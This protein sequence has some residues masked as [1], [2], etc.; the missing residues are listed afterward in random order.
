AQLEKLMENMRAEVGAHPPV[1]GSYSPRRGDFCI[2][3]FVDGEWYRARVEKVESG[4]KVHIFYID[5][6]NKETLPPSRLAPLPPAFSPRVLPPQATEYTFAFI[7]VPQDV[8]TGRGWGGPG[9]SWPGPQPRVPTVAPP[10]W[11]PKTTPTL[12]ASSGS[13][14]LPPDLHPNPKTP[15]WTPTPGTNPGPQP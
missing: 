6:G 15:P 12:N 11:V 1:E 4:G 10:P 8:S 5:Y 2:A 3:K 14:T 7:Q 13:Q 9:G